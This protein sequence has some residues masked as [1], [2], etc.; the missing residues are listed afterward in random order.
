MKFINDRN[1]KL[2]WWNKNYYFAATITVVVINIA[3]FM[4]LGSSWERFIGI[5]RINNEIY[6]IKWD[7]V[8]FFDN[9]IRNFLNC[10]SHS[11]WQHVLLNMLCFAVYGVYLER[12]HGTLYFLLLIVSMSFIASFA[13]SAN[14]LS[15]N[16]HGF[17]GVNYGFYAFVIID[18]IFSFFKGKTNASNIIS[19]A[20]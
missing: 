9:I 17:S 4:F 7:Y 15:V 14:Y 19:G 20:R 18:Y 13:V 16:C 11:N 6:V 2:T 10:Y 12:K 3:L 8:L 5:D 1:K